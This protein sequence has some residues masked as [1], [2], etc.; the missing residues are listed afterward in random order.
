MLSEQKG[1]GSTMNLGK[2]KMVVPASLLAV[3]LLAAAC[4][5]TGETRNE[6]ENIGLDGATNAEV[7]LR[8]GAGELDVDGGAS[9][10]LDADF[11][12]NVDDW[13]P[14]IDWGVTEGK[15]RL[16]IDQSGSKSLNLFDLDDIEYEWNLNLSDEIPTTLDVELGAGD[17]SLKLGSMALTEL[18]VETGAGDTTIDL[19][20][21]WQNDLDA[22]VDAGA[23]RVKLLLPADVGVRVETD[24][25]LVD[26]DNDG[27]TKDGDVYTNDAYGESD[28]TLTISVDAGVGGVIRA[29]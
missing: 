22:T 16:E 11:T 4:T 26:V 2:L 8:M 28:T 27:L 23:G 9:G 1:T 24:T 29:A 21:D 10:M 20:G 15:G 19:T 25:G 6:S 17:S 18:A 13:E 3:A 12:Y 14:E 7:F 5:E